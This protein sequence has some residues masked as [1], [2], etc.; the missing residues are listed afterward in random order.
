MTGG[1]AVVQG[2]QSLPFCR[3]IGACCAG[4]SVCLSRCLSRNKI[5]SSAA[6][7]AALRLRRRGPDNRAATRPG[8]SVLNQE[9]VKRRKRS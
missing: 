5:G 8:R 6:A 3:Q 2:R 1:G 7:Y 9:D 4:A